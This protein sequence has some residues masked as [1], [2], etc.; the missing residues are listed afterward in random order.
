[1]SATGVGQASRSR[2]AILLLFSSVGLL[3]RNF[4]ATQSPGRELFGGWRITRVLGM[5]PVTALSTGE[6]NGLVGLSLHYGPTEMT[7]AHHRYSVK[8]YQQRELSEDDFL[9]ENKVPLRRLGI[10]RNRLREISVEGAQYT[11]ADRLGSVVYVVDRQ[12]IVLAYRGVFLQARK[13]K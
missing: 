7:A 3:P 1:M 13:H 11:I 2:V 4:T 9:A 12:T 10:S 8:S 6:A 5:A